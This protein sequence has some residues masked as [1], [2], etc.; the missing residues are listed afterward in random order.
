MLMM[1]MLLLSREDAHAR[2]SRPMMGVA[3]IFDGF[4]VLHVFECCARTLKRSLAE[5][6]DG[7]PT[8]AFAAIS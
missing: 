7:K 6:A 2:S 3:L 5:G 8:R 4:W 1:M